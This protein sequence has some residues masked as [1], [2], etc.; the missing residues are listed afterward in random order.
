MNK[1]KTKKKLVVSTAL[2]SLCLASII[3]IGELYS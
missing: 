3:I 2:L 1:K